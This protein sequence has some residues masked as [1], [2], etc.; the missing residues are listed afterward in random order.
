[1]RCYKARQ[2]KDGRWDYTVHIGDVIL[3]VGYCAEFH[4]WTEEDVNRFGVPSNH[5][6]ILREKE[7]AHK[8]HSDGHVTAKDAEDCYKQYM[9]DQRLKLMISDHTN[10]RK[11]LC[12]DEW[13]SYYAIVGI[14]CFDLCEKH[15]TRESVERFFS[16]GESWSS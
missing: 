9:L 10:R 7:F 1:M 11:C 12:C 6:S 16:I 8:H 5:F 14:S 2:R 13:T 4:E 15:Q 3:P